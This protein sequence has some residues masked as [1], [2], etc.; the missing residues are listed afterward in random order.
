MH[1]SIINAS[2]IGE[3]NFAV[4]TIILEK[5]FAQALMPSALVLEQN[6]FPKLSPWQN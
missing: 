5:G 2:I 4:G 3:Y 6:P 1:D